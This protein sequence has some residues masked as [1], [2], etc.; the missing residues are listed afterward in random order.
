ME[1][2]G[3]EGNKRG[4]QWK[5][6]CDVFQGQRPAAGGLSSCLAPDNNLHHFHQSLITR[7]SLYCLLVCDYIRSRDINSVFCEFIMFLAGDSRLQYGPG[8]G[9]ILNFA[10]SVGI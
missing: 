9:Q 1:G 7:R 6:N 10:V 2:G 4:Q 8:P 5:M 3:R